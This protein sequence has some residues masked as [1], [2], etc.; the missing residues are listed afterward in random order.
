MKW[1]LGT[2]LRQIASQIFLTLAVST[3]PVKQVDPI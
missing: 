2:G 3:F 1:D